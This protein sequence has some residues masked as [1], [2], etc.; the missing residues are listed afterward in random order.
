MASAGLISRKRAVASVNPPTESTTKG[1]VPGLRF[2]RRTSR[3]R[4]RRTPATASANGG[5][6]LWK[7]HTDAASIIPIHKRPPIGAIRCRFCKNSLIARNGPRSHA[8]PP[9]AVDAVSVF[10][11]ASGSGRIWNFTTLLMVPLPVSLWNGARV[12]QVVH[13][14]LPFHPAFESSILPSIPFEKKPVG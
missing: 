9:S 1:G 11:C 5:R 10:Y 8:P 14:P 2:G 6:G 12:A 7:I 4:A 13:S 3:K